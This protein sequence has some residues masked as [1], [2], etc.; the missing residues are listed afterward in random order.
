MKEVAGK[1]QIEL[2]AERG[3]ATKG[4][5]AIRWGKHELS[6]PLRLQLAAKCEAGAK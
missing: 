4:K 5:L 3:D 6:A 2:G 1:L